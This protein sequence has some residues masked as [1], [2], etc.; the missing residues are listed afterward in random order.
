M[1]SLSITTAVGL[2]VLSLTS[3]PAQAACGATV[4]GQP[5]SAQTCWYAT[6]I[7]GRVLPGAYKAND[8]GDWLHLQT[9]RRGNT[10]RDAR[11]NL[12]GTKYACG[13]NRSIMAQGRGASCS[14]YRSIF[15][16]F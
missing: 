2:F 6:L 15:A 11:R 8:Q 7:Y 14:Q 4:N 3:T 5:M 1:K 13:G 12:R 16:E 9:G 10:V